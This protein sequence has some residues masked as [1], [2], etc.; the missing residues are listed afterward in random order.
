LEIRICKP[1]P[2]NS[3]SAL[4]YTGSPAGSTPIRFMIAQGA[5]MNISDDD[6]DAFAT[7]TRDVRPLKPRN[8]ASLDAPRPTPKARQSR[9]ARRALLEQSI[10]G[11][12]TPETLEEVG[13]RRDGVSNRVFRRLKR[14]EFAIEA[15]IDLH[16][17]RLAEAERELKRFMRECIERRLSSVRIVHGKGA[18]SGP[19]G[20]VLKPSVHH[21]LS[22]WDQVLAFATAQPRHG[23]NG[24]VYVL[25]G[26]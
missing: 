3:K 18:R 16:G 23:G 22:R 8:Q 13:F 5:A 2:W 19:D 26:R 14:G 6:R 17:M 11:P 12:F 21:W 7:A 15:E 24:A 9:A 1:G 4:N 10:E 25:L 20:P